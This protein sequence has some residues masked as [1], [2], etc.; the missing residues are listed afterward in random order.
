V[1]AAIRTISWI[2]ANYPGRDRAE[3]IRNFLVAAYRDWGML[4][5]LLA[6]DEAIIPSRL[7]HTS[8]YGG[9]DIA[10]D[11]YYGDLDGTWDRDGDGV[12]GEG[13]L[14]GA[15][16]G[17]SLDLYPDVFVG[18]ATVETHAEAQTFVDKTLTYIRTPSLGYQNDALFVAEVVFPV[19]WEPPS[20]S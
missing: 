17:D 14:S 9:E 5:V 10:S 16:P 15:S 4:W 1:P 13:W 19:G 8:T 20:R 12:F 7:A 2:D 18:R 6:G 11:L 3:R